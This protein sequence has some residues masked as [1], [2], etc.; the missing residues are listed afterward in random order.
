MTDAEV[1]AMVRAAFASA[2]AVLTREVE[3]VDVDVSLL[4]ADVEPA[5]VVRVLAAFAAA[6]FD[7]TLPDGGRAALARIG[8][9]L[10]GDEA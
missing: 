8:L 3:S 9:Q 4:L 2:V 1:R 7:A 6:V 5:V 10:A